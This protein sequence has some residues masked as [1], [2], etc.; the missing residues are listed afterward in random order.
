MMMVMVIMTVIA[1]VT[2][3]VI[4]IIFCSFSVLQ[5]SFL[6]YYLQRDVKLPCL[7]GHPEIPILSLSL[8]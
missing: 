3:I 8:S 4:T 2:V 5:I 7:N 1:M 6:C